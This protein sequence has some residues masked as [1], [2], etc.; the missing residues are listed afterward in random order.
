MGCAELIKAVS[1]DICP[2]VCHK[3]K[4]TQS[5]DPERALLNSLSKAVSLI[6]P[7]A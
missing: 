1:L 5:G 7:A 2:I 4:R 6:L 3:I